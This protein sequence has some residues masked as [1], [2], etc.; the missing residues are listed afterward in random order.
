DGGYLATSGDIDWY[1]LDL[2]SCGRGVVEAHV[3]FATG[4]LPAGF[5][6]EVRLLRSHDNSVCTLDQ[7][8]VSLAERCT[9][10]D[11]CATWGHS[12]GLDGYCE[13]AG[14]CLPNER[15]GANLLIE[16]AEPGIEG[17]VSL[18]APLFDPGP[19]WLG[20]SDHRGDAH[21]PDMPYTIEARVRRDPDEHEPN[22]LYTGGPPTSSQAN[23]HD[24]HAVTLPVHHCIDPD[25]VDTG[26]TGD[27]GGPPPN[28]KVC[29]ADVAW[30]EGFLSYDYDQDWFRYAHPCPGEDCMVRLHVEVDGGP[31]DTLVQVWRRTS[32]WFDGITGVTDLGLQ[33]P[34]SVSYGGLDPADECFYAYQGHSGDPYWYHVSLRDTLFAGTG[35]PTDGTWDH[36][37]EQRY[38]ICV[39]KLAEACLDPCVVETNGCDTP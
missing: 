37:A 15:C 9:T 39:E 23:L 14:L 19:V 7:D 17:Q 35:N 2:S 21:S 12:C 5:E 24:N 13:G 10:D 6:S 25:P 29:C 4:T 26:A 16:R 28:P 30:T 33:N 34:I 8:C 31:V 27:T 22:N 32:L 1:G 38:R 20:V 36:S 18:S 11:D 3:Q